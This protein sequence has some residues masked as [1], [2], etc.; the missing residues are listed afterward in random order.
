MSL[1]C[2]NCSHSH[3]CLAHIS[4]Q[5]NQDCKGS[6]SRLQ[7]KED[8]WDS[9]N[10]LHH[11]IIHSTLLMYNISTQVS[12]DYVYKAQPPTVISF[13]NGYDH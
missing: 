4:A 1:Y 6:E 8:Q 11:K 12:A 2:T 7:L 10:T 13:F 5:H 3:Q 9:Y